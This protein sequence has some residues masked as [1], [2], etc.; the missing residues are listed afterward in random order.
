M[1]S[2]MPFMIGRSRACS[3]FAAFDNP[4]SIIIQWKINTLPPT[5]FPPFIEKKQDSGYKK[6]QRLTRNFTGN[7][8]VGPRNPFCGLPE[9]LSKLNYWSELFSP[10]S[11]YKAK[12]SEKKVPNEGFLASSFKSHKTINILVLQKLC[13]DH[14][15]PHPVRL[16]SA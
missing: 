15:V 8:L 6:E 4:V 1:S 2:L 13:Y 10:A 12:S 3:S 9:N 7:P 11:F 16:N 5:I 14:T